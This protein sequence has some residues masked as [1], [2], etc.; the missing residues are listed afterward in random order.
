MSGAADGTAPVHQLMNVI[1]AAGNRP[2]GA[3]PVV[4]DASEAPAEVL[5]MLTEADFRACRELWEPV[6]RRSVENGPGPAPQA[7]RASPSGG[8]HSPDDLFMQLM[9]EYAEREARSCGL[10]EERVHVPGS[11]RRESPTPSPPLMAGSAKPGESVGDGMQPD[12]ATVSWPAFCAK[13]AAGL[14][15]SQPLLRSRA[16]TRRPVWG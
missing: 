10:L 14:F 3:K 13:W 6:E 9:K 2:H 15:V 12:R 1:K 8:G 11:N 5:D 4:G 16:T 7:D